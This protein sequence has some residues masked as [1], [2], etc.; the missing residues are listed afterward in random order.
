M[1]Y[2]R[3]EKK[4]KRVTIKKRKQFMTINEHTLGCMKK[5]IKPSN[6]AGK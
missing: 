1:D 2:S 4:N 6:V 5:S 3:K